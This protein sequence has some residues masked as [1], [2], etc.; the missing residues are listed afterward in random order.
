MVVTLIEFKLFVTNEYRK[1]VFI[2]HVMH[3]TITEI[4]KGNGGNMRKL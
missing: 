4:K 2:R 1:V 3:F